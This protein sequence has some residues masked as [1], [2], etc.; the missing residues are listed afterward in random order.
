MLAINVLGDDNSGA[1][2]S[3]SSSNMAPK[4][5]TKPLSEAQQERGSVTDKIDSGESDPGTPLQETDTSAKVST[6]P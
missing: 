5:K 1:P 3:K 4:N 2:M 6:K